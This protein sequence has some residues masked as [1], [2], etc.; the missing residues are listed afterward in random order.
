VG[1]AVQSKARPELV[2]GVKLHD[3]FRRWRGS[4]RASSWVSRRPRVSRLR[5]LSR[6]RSNSPTAAIGNPHLNT[7]GRAS[8]AAR[9]T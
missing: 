2:G 6:T 5:Q 8:S 4:D 9:E 1:Y 7:I 3:C